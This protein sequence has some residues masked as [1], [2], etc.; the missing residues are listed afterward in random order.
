MAICNKCRHFRGMSEHGL[1]C[2]EKPGSMRLENKRKT[3]CRKFLDIQDEAERPFRV[4]A[5]EM[6]DKAEPP[7]LMDLSRRPRK[8]TAPMDASARKRVALKPDGSDGLTADSGIEKVRRDTPEPSAEARQAPCPEP[9][10]H[11]FKAVKLADIPPSV[12]RKAD[13][14]AVWVCDVLRDFAASGD[15]AWE[16]DKGFEGRAL[17]AKAAMS[18]GKTMRRKMKLL[19]IP[20]E[21]TQRGALLYL[22]RRTGA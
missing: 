17:D 12:I 20:C 8:V 5:D 7:D 13:A 3:R 19:D 18:L 14:R 21:A 11:G 16:I 2:E 10:R 4:D 15:E 22:I 9:D 1:K 6:L